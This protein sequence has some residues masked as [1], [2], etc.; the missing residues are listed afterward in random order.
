L[1]VS[2]ATGTAYAVA[3]FLSD[4]WVSCFSYSVFC[5]E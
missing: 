4:S 2:I 3:R 1:K 5:R